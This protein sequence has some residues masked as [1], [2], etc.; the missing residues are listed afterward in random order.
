MDYAYVPAYNPK[1]WE[2]LIKKKKEDVTELAT[3]Q[4]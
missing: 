4:K 1:E 2:R 3:I